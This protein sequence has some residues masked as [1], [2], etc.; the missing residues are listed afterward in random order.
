MTSIHFYHLTSSPL[1]R[2]LPKLLEKCYASGTK[3]LVVADA[4]RLDALDELLWTCDPNSFLPH[5]KSGSAD[6]S[7]QPVLLVPGLPDAVQEN[8]ILC[9]T[10]GT[11]LADS[12]NFSRVLDVFDGND[13]DALSAARTRWKSYK[14]SGF[15]LNYY[16][17]TEAGGWQKKAVA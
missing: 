6:D 14:D 2:A 5:G 15:E 1:S 9:I 11:Y 16:Q 12:S 8:A 10:N 3:T 4:E 13:N 7:R 17:Q